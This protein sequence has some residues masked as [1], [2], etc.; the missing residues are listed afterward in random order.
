MHLQHPHWLPMH[1]SFIF[2]ILSDV[3][4]LHPAI[5]VFLCVFIPLFLKIW[6]NTLWLFRHLWPLNISK[7][8]AE[9]KASLYYWLVRDYLSVKVKVSTPA[10]FLNG[11]ELVLFV[12]SL[13]LHASLSIFKDPHIL[14][15]N[16]KN[17]TQLNYA[18]MQ[19]QS[20]LALLFCY[21]SKKY[22]FLQ[23]DQ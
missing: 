11:G 10:L 6:S 18:F 5:F 3:H 14:V 21:N 17:I 13:S 12:R 15:Q 1:Y 20:N 22:C 23:M 16:M 19:N 9:M 2:I 4:K 8:P 7:N